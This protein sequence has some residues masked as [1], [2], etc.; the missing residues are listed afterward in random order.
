MHKVIVAGTG[1][2][3]QK[4][5]EGINGLMD[6]LQGRN[7]PHYATKDYFARMM[8]VDAYRSFLLVRLAN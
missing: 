5:A 4:A 7:Y 1:H 6:I 8:K 2:A 3:Y